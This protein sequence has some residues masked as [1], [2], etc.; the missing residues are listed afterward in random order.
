[1]EK[2]FIHI[3]RAGGTSVASSLP[4]G[5]AT[6][7]GHDLRDPDYRHPS[8]ICTEGDY[9]FAI[10]RNP[11]DRLVSAF[12]FLRAGG[13]SDA[14]RRDAEALGIPT[15]SFRDFVTDRLAEAATWQ[16]HLRPQS[17]YLRGVPRPRVFSFD[18][19][20]RAFAEICEELGVA[21]GELLD[22]NKSVPHQSGD[23]YDDAARKVVAEVYRDDIELFDSLVS[24]E[25]T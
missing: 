17:F 14:D 8:A 11:Y 25:E 1:M 6:Y 2:Y 18:D 21:G 15:M 24:G 23:Y 5:C 4:Y 13:N 16:I 20:E 10:V 3:P 9:V 12:D 7:L 19:K 22:Q